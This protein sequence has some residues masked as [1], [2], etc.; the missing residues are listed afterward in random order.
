MVASRKVVYTLMQILD[1]DAIELRKKG[2][3]KR[4][5]YFAKGPNY[6][7]HVDSY[8]KLKPFGFCINGCIDGFSRYMIWLNVYHTRVNASY[9][10]EAIGELAGRPQLVRGNMGTEN[11]HLARMQTFLSGQESFLYGASMHNHRIESFWYVL[12]KECAQFWVNAM[13]A[14]KDRGDFT[15]DAIDITLIQFCFSNLL[16]VRQWLHIE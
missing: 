5:L 14:L 16:Q 13:R 12:R 8:E 11:G 3:L 1:P 15:G 4:R 2:R 9:Y 6:L 10:V 7:W